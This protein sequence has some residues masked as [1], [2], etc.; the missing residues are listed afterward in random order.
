MFAAMTVTMYTFGK[1]MFVCVWKR[2]RQMNDNLI[3]RTATI[4]AILLSLLFTAATSVLRINGQHT[5]TWV[6]VSFFIASM[7]AAF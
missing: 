1:F 4:Q 7:R 3:L 6:Q 2:M 5:N